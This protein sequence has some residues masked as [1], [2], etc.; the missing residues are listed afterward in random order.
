MREIHL[1]SVLDHFWVVCMSMSSTSPAEFGTLVLA[2]GWPCVRVWEG[3]LSFEVWWGDL[4]VAQRRQHWS[5]LITQEIGIKR[6]TLHHY[7]FIFY[8]SSV[9]LSSFTWG[10][11][12]FGFTWRLCFLAESE[13]IVGNKGQKYGLIKTSLFSADD[14]VPDIKQQLA[15]EEVFRRQT[16][17]VHWIHVCQL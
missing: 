2:W 10:T 4:E 5:Y 16:K 7:G 15:E 9:V 8:L 12:F 11:P 17:K 13:M 3:L 1:G 14:D 6:E